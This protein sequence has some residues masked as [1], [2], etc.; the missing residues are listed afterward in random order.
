MIQSHYSRSQLVAE[1]PDLERLSAGSDP[2]ADLRP[3]DVTLSNAAL[4]SRSRPAFQELINQLRPWAVGLP[5]PL[6]RRQRV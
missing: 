2:V 5:D 3:I 1:L 6:N 4:T